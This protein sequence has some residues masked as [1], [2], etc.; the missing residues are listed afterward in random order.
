MKVIIINQDPL[1]VT[2]DQAKQIMK[3]VAGG[4]DVVII[5]GEMIK[6]S[7]IMGIRNDESG[8]RI[9]VNLWG[10]LPAGKMA[11]FYDDRRDNFG[12]GYAKYQAMKAKL[13]RSV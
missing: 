13:L 4:T 7:A 11:K 12:P 2:P 6:S 5:N 10:A 1:I 9:P 3:S 8:E